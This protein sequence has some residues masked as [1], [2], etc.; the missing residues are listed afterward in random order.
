MTYENLYAIIAALQQ[1]GKEMK[2]IQ[3]IKEIFAFLAQSPE[4]RMKAEMEAYLAD[5]K[6]I[7]ELEYRQKIWD[8]IER[9]KQHIN[10]Y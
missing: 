10:W 1:R 2:L 5:A 9:N 6:D 7:Y 3:K 4:E 8:G